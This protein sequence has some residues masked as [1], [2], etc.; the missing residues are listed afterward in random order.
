MGQSK[1]VLEAMAEALEEMVRAILHPGC[2][3]RSVPHV[4][5]YIADK[6][7]ELRARASATAEEVA[8]P[9]DWQALKEAAQKATPGPWAYMPQGDSNEY[10]I[11]VIVP[12]VGSIEP[13]TRYQEH[14][15]TV[16]VEP[17][18]PD[19][20]GHA[21]AK[22][23]ALANPATILRLLAELESRSTS[24]SDDARDAERYRWLRLFP[25]N[26]AREEW[27]RYGAG[28]ELDKV[29]VNSGD[30]LDAAIDIAI[31]DLSWQAKYAAIK[32]KE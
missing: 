29:Y 19:V 9:G 12:R 11:G 13:L 21:N 4:V 14:D 26:F 1:E 5:H 7:K 28:L 8:E 16:I 30:R 24:P 20:M 6:A 18:A 2:P 17:V 10:G 32:V 27:G 25:T 23:I 31:K 22:F 3:W 15:D